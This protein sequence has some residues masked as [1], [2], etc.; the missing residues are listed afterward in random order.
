LCAVVAERAVRSEPGFLVVPDDV[1]RARRDTVAAPIADV[2]LDVDGVELR[3]D[4]RVGRADFHA[5][6]ERAVLA[7]VAH[8]APGDGPL[9]RAP[10]D[11]LDVA[12]VLL[13][14][15]PGVVEAVEELR[16]MARQLIPLLAG[17]LPVLASEAER[18]VREEANRTRHV[19]SPIS[20]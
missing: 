20:P 12:P 14:E 19:G 7:D 18:G 15:L 6:R 11:E 9:R 2:V 8:H 17:A 16:L 5:A 1:V 4:D 10:F 13:V 3:P